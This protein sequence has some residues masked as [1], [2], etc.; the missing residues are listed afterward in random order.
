MTDAG[1]PEG[2]GYVP[3]A[4]SD[5]RVSV[6]RAHEGEVRRGRLL[7]PGLVPD[8]SPVVVVIGGTAPGPVLL[9]TAGIHGAEV[10][11]IEA[12]RRLVRS[13]AP[14]RLR[15]TVIVMPV[16][17]VSAFRE[18]RLYVNPLDGKNLNR[19][20][21]GQVRG[22]TSQRIAHVMVDE[23]LPAVDAVV[24]LHGG[25]IVEALEPFAFVSRSPGGVPNGAPH[26]APT[27]GADSSAA[28]PWAL[29]EALHLA[30]TMGLP[31]VILG[32]I[33]GS[34]AHVALTLGKPAF[35]AEAGGQGVVDPRAVELLLGGTL[36]V[37][38]TL[39]MREPDPAAAD[40]APPAAQPSVLRP[41]WQWVTSPG[42]GFWDPAVHVA[43]QVRTGDL[44]GTVRDLVKDEVTHEVAAPRDGRVVFLVTALS[45]TFGTPL[46]AVAADPVPWDAG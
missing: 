30:R 28:P 46:C 34:L 12:A 16:V 31:Q 22:S 7:V 40:A 13:V 42:D 11:S 27:V 4:P 17:N 35:I 45:T 8:L 15:G 43:A 3:R 5:V 36:R 38:A 21:P 26:E 25:D 9:V 6:F 1:L 14:E 19:V 37:M 20:F 41:S 33:P 39:G 18:R 2:A 23:V 29:R 32:E 24:D 44:L 10:S